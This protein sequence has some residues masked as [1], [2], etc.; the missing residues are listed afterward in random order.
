MPLRFFVV[1]V[2]DSGAFEQDLNGFLAR[3]RAVSIDRQLIDQ[4]ANSFWQS[5]AIHLFLRSCGQQVGGPSSPLVITAV[6]SI[7]VFSTVRVKF[8]GTAE[9]PCRV[10]SGTTRNGFGLPRE[11]RRPTRV[12]LS[13]GR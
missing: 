8:S 13:P 4:G 11:A 5:G 10:P 1:P 9:S 2:H 12:L 7:A 6:T 3:H